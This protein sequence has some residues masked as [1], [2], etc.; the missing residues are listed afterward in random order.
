MNKMTNVLVLN[1][2]APPGRNVA[3]TL[4]ERKNI[5]VFVADA[6]PLVPILYNTSEIN[7]SYVLPRAETAEYIKALSAIVIKEKIKVIIPCIEDEILGL[8][9][10]KDYFSKMSV[11]VLCVEYKK[12]IKIAD[13]KIITDIAGKMNIPVPRTYILKDFVDEKIKMSFPLVVKPRIGHGAKETFMLKDRKG[14]KLMLYQLSEDANNYIIQHYN[15][16][17]CRI[18]ISLFSFKIQDY[19]WNSTS[20][21]NAHYSYSYTYCLYTCSLHYVSKSRS[22]RYTSWAL[23][24]LCNICTPSYSLD[25]TKLL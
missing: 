9:K 13:K 7:G 15:C 12:V 24:N 14:F 8:S 23:I 11:A 3:R 2:G 1:V 16:S 25:I 6:D 21:I 22:T 5:K 4:I 17:K 10:Y 18:I 19:G 20:R